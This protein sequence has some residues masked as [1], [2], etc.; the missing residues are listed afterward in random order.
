METAA[1]PGAI[2]EDRHLAGQPQGLL[3]A[4]VTMTRFHRENSKRFQGRAHP[5]EPGRARG[6]CAEVSVG[7]TTAVGQ[8]AL[9]MRGRKCRFPAGPLAP[10]SAFTC[11]FRLLPSS[12]V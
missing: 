2:G 3:Q 6:L 12:S 7:V 4:G 5:L 1:F 11:S 8:T 10:F 9:W